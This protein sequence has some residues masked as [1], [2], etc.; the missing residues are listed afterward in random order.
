VCVA[1]LERFVD[2]TTF[3]KSNSP[4]RSKSGAKNRSGSSG[5]ATAVVGLGS[6]SDLTVDYPLV[7]TLMDEQDSYLS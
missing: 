6:S 4:R 5:S 1:Q 7:Q 3:Q 2:D